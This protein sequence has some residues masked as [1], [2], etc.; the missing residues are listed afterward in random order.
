MPVNV[1][2]R[3]RIG[4][5]LFCIKADRNSLHGTDI[6][7]GA[8]LLKISKRNMVRLFVNGYGR[9]RCRYFLNKRKAVFQIFFIGTVYVFFQGRAAQSARVP[10]RHV[11]VLP[12]C[13]AFILSVAAG[14]RQASQ[15]VNNS[16]SG[17]CISSP[18]GNTIRHA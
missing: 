11:L 18:S 6:I 15:A 17:A 9:N 2:Q 5:A 7:H 12:G 14:F 16:G 3:K 13:F 1:L 10:C 4:M 8:F